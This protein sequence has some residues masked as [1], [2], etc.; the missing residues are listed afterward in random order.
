MR[1]KKILYIILTVLHRK[2]VKGGGLLV[3]DPRLTHFVFGKDAEIILNGD[4]Q[5][6][7]NSFGNN[8]RS[9]IVRIDQGGQM[10][11]DGHFKLM[12]GADVIVFKGGHLRC[13]KNSF[14]NSDCKVRCHKAISIGEGCKISHDLTLMDSDA[15][16]LEGD[17]HTSEVIIEDHVWIASRVTVLS[18]TRIGAGSVVATGSVV[19]GT[20]PPCSLIGGTPARIIR[21]NVVWSD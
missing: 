13:G 9:N 12:Y 8:G 6:G 11:V 19:R 4:L 7:A 2:N 1:G 10:T 3:Y 5:I 15:H 16:H 21:S 18:G 20:F 17:N 14:I